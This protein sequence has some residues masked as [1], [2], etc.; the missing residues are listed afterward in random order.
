MTRAI[1]KSLNPLGDDIVE[2]ATEN[3][4]LKSKIGSYD[5]KWVEESTAK[6]LK[7]I[8][9]DRRANLIKSR[10]KKTDE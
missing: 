8:N 1:K 7:Q 5:E 10:M 4:A 2:L 3:D 9:D 6:L